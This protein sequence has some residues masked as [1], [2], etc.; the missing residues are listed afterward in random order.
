MKVNFVVVVFYTTQSVYLDDYIRAIK[1]RLNI[2]VSIII[3]CVNDV[4]LAH[5]VFVRMQ[6]DLCCVKNWFCCDVSVP[7]LVP[8]C[9][10]RLC[11]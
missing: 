10:R 2:S 3:I 11:S 9:R 4:V 6:K 8:Q 5:S 1:R 7:A